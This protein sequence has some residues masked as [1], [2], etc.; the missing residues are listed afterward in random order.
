MTEHGLDP[1]QKDA[2]AV[3][4]VRAGDQAARDELV[5]RYREIV[6]ALAYHVLQDLHAAED[7]C[8]EALVRAFQDLEEL[9]DPISFGPWLKK[10]TLREC[11]A[12]VR[13]D[14]ARQRAE[15]RA[16]ETGVLYDPFL[17]EESAEEGEVSGYVLRVEEAVEKL[18]GE[19]CEILALFYVKEMS[20]EEISNFL[21]LPRGTVKR[22]L[23]D[24]R[25]EL[26]KSVPA[27]RPRGDSAAQRFLDAFNRSLEDR[28]EK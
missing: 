11:S 22:R 23:F 13:R 17:E 4:R 15:E 27:E 19:H 7:T 1:A 14:A 2:E 21:G 8:Q 24:A 16:L 18:S 28:L 26:Q 20:H 3:V 10:I 25:Q 9:R 12:W 5:L 6:H